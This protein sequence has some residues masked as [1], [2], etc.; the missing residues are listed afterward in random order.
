MPFEYKHV[1]DQPL[2]AFDGL[3]LIAS[4]G[5]E[6]ATLRSALHHNPTQSG[7]HGL[8]HVPQL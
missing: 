4:T 7:R 2:V 5:E 6:E 1:G 8:L 3:V